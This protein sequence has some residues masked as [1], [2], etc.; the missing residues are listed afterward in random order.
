MTRRN[1]LTPIV[2]TFALALAVLP[3]RASDMLGMYGLIDKVV[4]E[5]DDK[6]PTAVQVWGAF[7]IANRVNN[8]AGY[9]APEQGY[10]YY[11]CPKAQDTKC[12]SE[13]ADLKAAATKGDIVGFGSRYSPSGRLRKTTEK[14]AAPDMYPINIGVVKITPDMYP[15]MVRSLRA[16]AKRK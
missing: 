4:L 12:V 16:M 15:D 5:P 11:S 10:F 6:E 7:A 8:L 13:W 3:L 1:V 2:V 14:V 9:A